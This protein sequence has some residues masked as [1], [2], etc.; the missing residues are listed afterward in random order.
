MLSYPII[1]KVHLA[2][3][4]TGKKYLKGIDNGRV[5]FNGGGLSPDTKLYVGIDFLARFI[6]A[7]AVGMDILATQR[8]D[9]S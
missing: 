7:S 9:R 5:L 6:I 4:H 3:T 1:Q 2:P 8:V